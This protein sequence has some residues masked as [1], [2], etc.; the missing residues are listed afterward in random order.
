MDEITDGELNALAATKIMGWELLTV[1]HFGTD[2]ET[3]RQK[4][5]EE[6]I[7]EHGIE[8]VG[9]YWIKANTHLWINAEYWSPT[10]DIS[11]A[12]QVLE[13]FP[14]PKYQIVVK[15][16]PDGWTCIN[17]GETYARANAENA[18]KAIVLAVLKTLEKE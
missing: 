10:T 16:D 12:W 17:V 13:K 2:D 9:S 1:G 6:W 3:P 11:Q 7:E 14:Y 8:S 18:A 5:L 15:S 4:E